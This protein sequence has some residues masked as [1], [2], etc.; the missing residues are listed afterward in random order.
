MIFA[1]YVGILAFEK[2]ISSPKL[3][4]F[5][6]AGKDLY[7]S[8]QLGVLNRSA[9]RVQRQTGLYIRVFSCMGLLPCVLRSKRVLLA[10][11]HIE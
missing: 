3:D 11:F 5:T 9:S 8:S 10:R 6:L 4:R 2:I 7:L 1:F